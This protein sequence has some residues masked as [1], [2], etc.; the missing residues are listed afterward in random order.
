MAPE[1][2]S[3]CHF[4]TDELNLLANLLMNPGGQ[5][6][7]SALDDRRPEMTLAR[8]IAGAFDKSLAKLRRVHDNDHHAPRRGMLLGSEG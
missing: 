2:V 4:E 1:G 5:K 6:T 7:H 8:E 3:T